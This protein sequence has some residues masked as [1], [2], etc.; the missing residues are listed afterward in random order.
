L[1]G[2]AP[3]APDRGPTPGP[4][5]PPLPAGRRF[6][7]LAVALLVLVS[8]ALALH[9][10]SGDAAT[11]DE[12]V[13][14]AAGV[15]IAREG[16]WRWNPE[17]P[18]LAKALAGLAL[19]GL[20]LTP[21]GDPVREPAHAALLLRFLFEN[22]TRAETVLFRAR[23]PF[24]AVLVALLLAVRAEA[25]RRF[26]PAA[27]LLALG[28]AAFEPNLVAHAGVVHT[29]LLLALWVV[30]SLAPLDRLGGEPRRRDVLRLGLLWGLALLSKYSAPLVAV[31]TLPL[32]A[33]ELR[34]QPARRWLRAGGHVAAAGG[35]ALAVTLA[36]FSLAARH[37]SGSDRHAL[38]EDRLGVMGRAPAAAAFASRVGDLLP[39]AGNLLTGA[40]S[41]VL[42]SRVGAMPNYFLGHVSGD[43]SAFYFPVAL[44]TK[45]SLGL[46]LATALGASATRGRRLAAGAGTAVALFIAASATSTYNIGVRHVLFA[47]PLA[48]IVAAASDGRRLRLAALTAGLQAAELISVH[49]HELAFFNL[50]A[51]G[52]DGGRRYFV[53][54]NLDWGQELLRLAAAAPGLAPGGL[55]TVHFGGDLPRRH[56]PALR[57]VAPGDEDRP[58]TV[59]AIGEAPFAIGPE[60]LA[61][62]GNVRDA[63]RLSALRDTLRSRGERIGTIGGAIGIWRIREAP[64]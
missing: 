43:G 26:G 29:D 27:G 23:L 32:L 9:H 62:K 5:E 18:P 53:D 19:T 22:Q 11:T 50:A 42:Q 40:L 48:A 30:L 16:T 2:G 61:A 49:P 28:L 1:N 41:I 46:L 3:A 10:L 7:A 58:G 20:P 54:S 57:P 55:P 36:G 44:A 24:V 14:I 45:A 37:Q 63:A 39:A 33:L 38:S 52:P 12:P 31:V 4:P 47:F 34:G 56:A 8:A 35:L 21:A 51:G 60:V 6:E 64:R 25:R 17:H 15:E 13:H 59:L